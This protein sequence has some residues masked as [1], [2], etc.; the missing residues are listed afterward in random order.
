MAT[1]EQIEVLRDAIRASRSMQQWR[2]AAH[3]RGARNQAKYAQE[4]ALDALSFFDQNIRDTEA[5]GLQ[6]NLSRIATKALS[7]ASDSGRPHAAS[8]DATRSYRS[9]RPTPRGKKRDAPGVLSYQKNVKDSS[10]FNAHGK[11][12]EPYRRN[13]SPQLSARSEKNINQESVAA[14]TETPSYARYIDEGIGGTR[15]QIRNERQK[16]SAEAKSRD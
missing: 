2:Q 8:R 9:Q 13:Y 11:P 4:R 6:P 1:E 14:R 5:K 7:W 12:P 16:L 10:H 3:A 15:E